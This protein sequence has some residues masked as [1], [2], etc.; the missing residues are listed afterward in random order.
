M[1]LLIEAKQ[2]Y[3]KM[4]ENITNKVVITLSDD[5]S[6]MSVF[7]QKRLCE[8]QAFRPNFDRIKNNTNNIA[9]N[10]IS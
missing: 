1:P 6:S 8:E 3:E 4:L 10:Q 7:A 2:L 5:T 9:N